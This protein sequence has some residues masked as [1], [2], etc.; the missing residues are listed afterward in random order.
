MI[1][2][3]D[4]AN[5]SAN[6]LFLFACNTGE[7][8]KHQCDLARRG[9]SLKTWENHVSWNVIKH[10]RQDVTNDEGKVWFVSKDDAREVARLLKAYYETHVKEG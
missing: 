5:V 3:H 4:V 8:Y 10:W 2:A 6:D 7:I 9:A 1:K